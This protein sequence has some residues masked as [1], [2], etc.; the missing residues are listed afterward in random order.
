HYLDLR[1]LH[2]FTFTS[3]NLV[4]SIHSANDIYDIDAKG[5]L[6]SEKMMIRG[7]NY[8]AGK[9]FG[10]DSHIVYDDEKK[11]LTIHPSDLKLKSSSFLVEGTYAWKEKNLIN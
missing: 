11:H 4:A 1:T 6:T 5:Q 10:V 9:A 8:F 7:N 3:E 2:D